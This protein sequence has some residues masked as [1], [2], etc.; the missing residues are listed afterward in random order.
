MIG[1]ARIKQLFRSQNAAEGTRIYLYDI[2]INSGQQFRDGGW[3][4]KIDTAPSGAAPNAAELETYIELER[5]DAT[6]QNLGLQLKGTAGNNSSLFRVPG[7]RGKNIS[8]VG[9]TQQRRYQETVAVSPATS[10]TITDSNTNVKFISSTQW[11]IVNTSDRKLVV[12]GVNGVA[13]SGIN[14]NNQA[15]ITGL[16]AGK[17]Y[18]V[19]AQV[20]VPKTDTSAKTKTLTRAT[21]TFSA[22]SVADADFVTGLLGTTAYY[23]GAKLVSVTAGTEDVTRQFIFDGGQ[24]DNYIQPIRLRRAGYVSTTVG[25][26]VVLDYF[27]W[28]ATGDYF[29]VNSYLLKTPAAATAT[30][31]AFSY[32]DIPKFVS[33][34][35]GDIYDLRNYIDFRPKMNPLS[36]VMASA[37]RIPLPRSNGVVSYDAEFYNQRKDL[38]S[39]GYDP[40][41]FEPQIR[42]HEGVEAV[43]PLA[44]DPIDREM[45]LF[46]VTY[47]GNTTGPTD[48]SVTRHRYK[49]FTMKDIARLEDRVEQLEETVS[50]TALEASAA[51]LIE[52]DDDGLIRS[53]TGFF[54]DDFSRGFAYTASS[55]NAPTGENS[56]L[57]WHEDPAKCGNSI[58][59]TGPSD[60]PSW[61]ITPKRADVP[62]NM[63][64]DA[65]PYGG[66]ESVYSRIKTSGAGTPNS[67]YIIKGDTVLLDYTD[68]LDPS[69]VNEVISWKTDGA[70][71]NGSGYYNVNPFNVFTGLGVLNL[72]PNSDDWIDDVHLPDINLTGP[73]Q[74]AGTIITS[75]QTTNPANGF[76]DRESWSEDAEGYDPLS[77]NWPRLP[78]R[79]GGIPMP[80]RKEVTFTSEEAVDISTESKVYGIPWMRQRSI[81]CKATDLRP[82]TRY[83]PFF[84]DVNVSQ[85]CYKL[86]KATY[87]AAMANRLWDVVPE[88]ITTGQIVNPGRTAESLNL[89]TD[90]DGELYYNFWLPNSASVASVAENEGF[91]KFDEWKDWIDAQTAAAATYGSVNDFRVMNEN[92]WKFPS[93]GA[94]MILSDT[95]YG[96]GKTY[97]NGD[98]V[99]SMAKATYESEGTINLSQDTYTTYN[100]ITTNI[101]YQAFDPLAQSFYVDATEGTSTGVF[102]TKVDVFLRS[103]PASTDTQT[104]VRL[105]IREMIAGVPFH[106]PPND[107]FK[108]TKKASEVR[109][110]LA[111]IDTA[112]GLE[113]H[114]AVIANPVTFEF[115]QPIYIRSGV[116]YAIV[117]LSDCDGYEAFVSTTYDL[118]LGKNTERVSQQ[119][120]KGAFFLS[121]NGSTW[122]ARQD[123]NLAYRIYT[124]KFKPSGHVNFR[125]Q[126]MNPFR[127]N[128]KILSC[129]TGENRFRVNQFAHGLAQGDSCGLTGLGADTYYP[130]NSTTR[131]GGVKGSVLMGGSAT[132][133]KVTDADADGYY[134]TLPATT[135]AAGG[136]FQ[137]ASTNFGLNACTTNQAFNFEYGM[138]RMQTL[139]FPGTSIDY[140]GSFIKGVSLSNVDTAA[141]VDERFGWLASE[142]KKIGNGLLTTFDTPRMLANPQQQNAE[143]SPLTSNSPSIV[144]GIDLKSEAP[145]TG[146]GGASAITARTNGFTQDVSPI[147]SLGSASY[148]MT[149]WQI[150]NQPLTD[151]TKTDGQNKPQN[152]V[153]ETDHRSGSSPSKH[154]TKPITLEQVSVGL[155]VLIDIYKPPASAFDLYY[156]T[157]MEEDI[158]Q[159]DW[160]LFPFTGDLPDNPFSSSS[161][162]INTLRYTEY[163]FLIGGIDGTAAQFLSF[164]L[165]IVMRSTNACQF[166]LIRSIRTIALAT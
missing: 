54:V 13:V 166:P 53:K 40:K 58:L 114:A 16:V 153:S 121:S 95:S 65:T 112:G 17:S 41:T 7:P 93:G 36:S 101:H 42:I 127:H 31:P 146:F 50:L 22:N 107:S 26:T 152:Y 79:W 83:W 91:T 68:V 140:Q 9:M 62:I 104:T 11:I 136:T 96:N 10:I 20:I 151:V 147:M 135:G 159:Q 115:E 1:S 100:K 32:S 92:G 59:A 130:E 81:Y 132:L 46:S 74:D 60:S 70:D 131:S 80:A 23:D 39:L 61:R 14:G 117:L 109:T 35:S 6:T 98:K 118:L 139:D 57:R 44:K 8:Y 137:G 27:V 99:L 90:A 161:F 34:R 164:Q 149:N 28:S 29:S 126:D 102:I 49:R 45:V 38:I 66:I 108:S 33:P 128:D 162:N 24:H 155:K 71:Y 48:V 3:I 12:V 110:V 4:S 5:D 97:A 85:F 56:S 105:E 134:V 157:V 75:T 2:K 106:R 94:D 150:D 88:A 143:V 133:G 73:D 145:D 124:A 163:P 158:L 142:Q 89:V 67:N 144:V 77:E 47:G 119:P 82:N 113:N 69:L 87:N 116:E 120:A 21:L 129:V 30:N 122:N 78:P 37:D 43:P 15:T 19:F 148:S 111:A 72:K 123:Q 138:F 55:G 63:N 165:K 51:N 76:S 18:T 125:N 160:T 84:K 103:A 156:R 154:I 64:I 25:I 52:V 86:E 141:I